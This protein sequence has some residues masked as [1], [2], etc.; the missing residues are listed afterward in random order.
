LRNNPTLKVREF[1]VERAHAES[2]GA[3]SRLLPQ[4]SAQASLTANRYSD[5]ITEDQSY[6]GQRASVNLR[7][8]VYEPATRRRLESSQSVVMQRQNEMAQV[9]VSLFGDLLD[10]YL[11]TLAAQDELA[12]LAAESRAATQHVERLSAMRDRQMAK[13]TDLVE[14]QAYAVG[15]VTRMIEARN[16]QSVARAR[17]T[18][19][20]GI[21]VVVV[22]ALARRSFDKVEGTLQE[23]IDSAQRA[24]P[25]LQALTRSLDAARSDL[26]AIRAERLPQVAATLS[27]VYSDQGF[28]NRSQP[29]YNATSIGV[30]VRVPIYLGGRFEASVRD[31]IA[32]VG[33]VEQ[34]RELAR[35]EVEREVITVWLSAQADH[36]R[37]DS[38]GTEVMAL[39][40]SV[41]AQEKGLELGV[42]RITDLLDAR[43]RLLKARADQAKARYD[44]VRDVVSLRI[45][46]GDLVDTDIAAWAGWFELPNR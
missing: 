18:E 39:E 14:A 46:R 24:S 3:R 1:A 26:E 8:A 44:F 2:D 38:T 27:H 15:L 45:L 32:R 40:Q 16:A 34:Q 22:P 31:A 9:R 10:R 5:S 30:E 36:A 43:R 33:S 25:R 11:Q 21:N 23:W 35:R 41:L 17:L 6:S 7:Q 12:S 13:V 29:A 19:L 4:I 28:D 42:S 37:I 20:S